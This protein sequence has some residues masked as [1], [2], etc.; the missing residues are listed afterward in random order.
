MKI[1]EIDIPPYN[2]SVE[3]DWKGLVAKKIN[4]PVDS[5]SG[6]KL[7]KRSID[8]RKQRILIH[9]VFEV[10]SEGELPVKLYSFNY[11]HI[12]DKARVIIVG[13][14]PAGLFAALRLI[15]LGIKP[16]ILDRGKP[17]EE[18]KTDI[19][20][21]NKSRFINPDSNYCFGEG[22]A[23]TYSD[24]KL[25]TRSTKRGDVNRILNI[26]HANG[27]IQDILVDAHP[28]IGTDKL[29]AIIA[30]IRNQILNCGG[31]IH[32]GE[33]VN[34]IIVRD[35]ATKGVTTSSGN[36][37]EGKAVILATGHS[38]TDIYEMLNLANILLEAKSFAIGVRIEHSQQLI[39][40]I[41]YHGVKRG[42][43]LPAAT[44][45]LVSQV[46]GKGVFSFCMCPGGSIVTASTSPDE[47]VLNGM[48]NSR[49]NLPYAN[50]GIVVTVDEEDI[51]G[52]D[53]VLAGLHFREKLEKDAFAAGG[54][55]LTA[56]AQRMMDFVEGKIS[57]QFPETSYF[58]GLKSVPLNELLP[59]FVSKRLKRAFTTFNN[60]MK[61]FY[62]NEAILLGVETRTSSPV[63]IP[64]HAE[65][66]EHIQIADLFPCGEGAGYSGGIVSSAIDG[67]R[68]AEAVA[69][70]ILI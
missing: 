11:K 69:K 21:I 43:F 24:G 50:S 57:S 26:F 48:S 66:L 15:E 58:P 16:V 19:A 53:G 46:E 40:N 29:P 62:T 51:K 61:G 33:R 63:R 44:Y 1:V 9:H 38:A 42:D 28:H 68:C 18:R 12:N 64:R 8:A 56:P 25:Y 70:K 23:G 13:S 27:A 2:T 17:V 36:T 10:Y 41:Q 45:N 3:K 31:E 59:A 32:F 4:I 52:F 34:N 49:R 67:E 20:A 55:N 14:G 7:V 6:A 37:F 54:S 47:L 39:D 65:T 5:I 30:S 60:K 35:G 22:G